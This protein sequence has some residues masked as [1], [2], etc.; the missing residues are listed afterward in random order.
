MLYQDITITIDLE[1]YDSDSYKALRKLLSNKT[2]SELK[3]HTYD[4]CDPT[5]SLTSEQLE[6][7]EF[8]MKGGI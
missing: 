8:L 3:I 5:K 7:V 4:P 1:E 2:L 6:V